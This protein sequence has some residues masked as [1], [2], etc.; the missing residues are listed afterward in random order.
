MVLER[1]QKQILGADYILATCTQNTHGTIAVLEMAI[2][3]QERFFCC[4]ARKHQNI[5]AML[6]EPMKNLVPQ[7]NHKREIAH[8][9]HNEA[10]TAPLCGCYDE[11]P[12]N[13]T[14]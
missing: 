14:K 7:Q 1:C 11:D 10:T 6:P 12:E 2:Q 4:N 9:N 3:S 5:M 13:Y 8:C